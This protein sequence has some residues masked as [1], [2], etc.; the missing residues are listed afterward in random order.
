MRNTDHFTSMINVQEGVLFER[1]LRSFPWRAL[2]VLPWLED[3][4]LLINK[5]FYKWKLRWY[6][7]NDKKE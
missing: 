1:I 3:I 6:T 7:D 4:S 5:L 2:V